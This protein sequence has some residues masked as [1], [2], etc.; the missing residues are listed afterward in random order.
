MG[1]AN[2]LEIDEAPLGTPP[3]AAEILVLP[4][5]SLIYSSYIYYSYRS[6]ITMNLILR[7]LACLLVIQSLVAVKTK[8]KDAAVDASGEFYDTFFIAQHLTY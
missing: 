1:D 6:F 4:F 8:A 7:L 2:H 5:L 3:E